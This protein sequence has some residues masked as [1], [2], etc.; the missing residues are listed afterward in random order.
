MREE[1]IPDSLKDDPDGGHC[2]VDKLW[3]YLKDMKKPGTSICEFDLLFEVANVV[4]T[5]LHSNAGEERVFSLINKNKTSSRSS[6]SY[7][8]HQKS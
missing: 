3:G 8:N 5:I 7:G 4:L 2:N 6:L 1:D